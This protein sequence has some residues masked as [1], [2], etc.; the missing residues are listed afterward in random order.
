MGVGLPNS[1]WNALGRRA[2]Y[3]SL[4]SFEA[5]QGLCLSRQTVPPCVSLN[6]SSLAGREKHFA[7]ALFFC[8]SPT[9]A[10]F[11]LCHGLATDGKLR[12]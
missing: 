8:P 6:G 3:L 12:R 5:T 10:T 11:L 7:V 4:G 9:M 2:F 1:T